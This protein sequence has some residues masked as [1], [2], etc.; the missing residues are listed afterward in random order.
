MN[1]LG[2]KLHNGVRLLEAYVAQRD[3]AQGGP[4]AYCSAVRFALNQNTFDHRSSFTIPTWYSYLC[5]GVNPSSVA[6]WTYRTE[7]V[8]P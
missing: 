2:Q 5:P 3:D 7:D 1:L 4:S 6:T 8:E